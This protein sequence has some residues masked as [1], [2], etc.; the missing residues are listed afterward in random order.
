MDTLTP[1]GERALGFF[2]L[3]AGAIS[4]ESRSRVELFPGVG[5]YVHPTGGKFK[6]TQSNLDAW[7]TDINERG[8]KISADYDHSFYHG[9]G[10]E[11][12]GWLVP[13]SATLENGKLMADVDWTD[14]AADKIKSKKYRFISPEF[15][16]KFKDAAG[17]LVD[18]PRLQAIALTNRPFFDSMQEVTISADQGLHDLI[19]EP[20]LLDASDV[21]LLSRVADEPTRELMTSSLQSIDAKTREQTRT[22]LMSLDEPKES[23]VPENQELKETLGLAEDASEEEIFAAVKTLREAQQK[24]EADKAAREA[25][26]KAHNRKTTTKE[27]DMD[28]SLIAEELGLSDDADDAT[29]IAALREARQTIENGR[30]TAD[31]LST[32]RTDQKERAKLE[33]RVKVIEAERRND[34]VK[35][36]LEDGVRAGKVIPAEKPILFK[37]FNTN[38]D[39]LAELIASRPDHVF[40]VRAVG[41]AGSDALDVSLYGV[42][43]EFS[44]K[45]GDEI[46]AESGR[47]HLR[48]L[49]VLAE[50]GKR[51][52]YTESEYAAALEIAGE[53]S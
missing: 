7:Q 40:S 2:T 46:D 17:K 4:A 38:P 48:A 22:Y 10:S 3:D 35:R 43:D 42:A 29:V 5:D 30:L 9:K 24:A 28:L 11:A 34:R 37:Q 25:K 23:H 32:L 33:E 31:E 47:L 49:H 1:E 13:G 52:R 14:E 53:T 36:M 8:D 21:E 26:L 18:K 41:S 12:A 45:D 51:G 6:I 15:A 44:D 27:N 16:F 20:R 19:Q 50:Q 39:A